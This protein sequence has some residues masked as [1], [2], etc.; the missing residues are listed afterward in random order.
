MSNAHPIGAIKTIQ[1][2]F[3][4]CVPLRF[5]SINNWKKK[6]LLSLV[7][8]T[9]GVVSNASYSEAPSARHYEITNLCAPEGNIGNQHMG[10]LIALA[11]SYHDVTASIR[12]GRTTCTHAREVRMLE[13]G[14]SDIFWAATSKEYESKIIPIRIPIFKGLLGHRIGVISADR[15]DDF[16]KIT[17]LAQLKQVTMG[18]GVGWTDT[19]ILNLAGFDITELPS[20]GRLY[21]MLS[22]KRFDMFPRGLMEPWEELSVYPSSGLA[23]ERHIMIV[24]PLPAYIF[25]TPR[26]P[27]LA[28]I[29]ES[30]LR[31]AIEDGEF[32]K[33]L[34]SNSVFVNAL[35]NANADKRTIFHIPNPT[36]PSETPLHDKRLW[37]DI[38]AAT[39]ALPQTSDM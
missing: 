19:A 5:P 1:F 17:T 6:C 9:L 35:R 36:L 31:L 12:Y 37:L 7:C 3:E 22:A 20:I 8:W 15:Q 11:L 24:Y 4:V 26:K 10:R 18:Q 25:V 27:E 16:A 2:L 38:K 28:S 14:T 34:F 30:G 32:D 13:Q 39:D 23:V 21:R 33:L 29:I